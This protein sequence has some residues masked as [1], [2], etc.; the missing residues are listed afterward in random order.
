MDPSKTVPHGHDAQT[1]GIRLRP[2]GIIYNDVK[3][4]FLAARDDG[5]EMAEDIK[6]VRERMR[7]TGAR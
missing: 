2:V 4:P 6:A 5:I 1:D 3:E 7:L